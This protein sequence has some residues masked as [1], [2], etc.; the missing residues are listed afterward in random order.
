MPQCD[1]ATTSRTYRISA[2]SPNPRQRRHPEVHRAD[3][4]T[5]TTAPWPRRTSA[6]RGRWRHQNQLENRSHVPLLP[7]TGTPTSTSLTVAGQDVVV[8]VGL[9]SS[10]ESLE[11]HDQDSLWVSLIISQDG[12]L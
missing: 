6:K 7:A 2:G 8:L 3:P 12:H 10:N 5:P 9:N 11:F 4:T 1:P